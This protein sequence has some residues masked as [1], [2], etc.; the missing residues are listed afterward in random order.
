L[1]GTSRFISCF[2]DHDTLLRRLHTSFVLVSCIHGWFASYLNRRAQCV[3]RGSMRSIIAI[4]MSGVPQGSVLGPILFLLY[5]ADL[6]QLIENHE[7]Q[8]HLYANDTQIYGFCRA[9]STDQ[10][11]SRVSACIG[12]VA[13]WMR[14]NR[15]QLNAIKTEVL[16]CASARLSA[17][18]TDESAV[19]VF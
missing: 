5:M 18:D 13:S 4:M 15:L 19:G 7:L 8:P 14:S 11:Q 12:D 16:W 1:T 6:L 9:G 3:R 2:R 10:L 17:S